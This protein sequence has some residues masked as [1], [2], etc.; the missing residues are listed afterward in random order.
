MC[1]FPISLHK[2]VHG[3]TTRYVFIYI[4]WLLTC[5]SMPYNLCVYLLLLPIPALVCLMGYWAESYYLE[6]ISQDVHLLWW[7]NS[8][9]IS[10]ESNPH[11]RLR[12]EK[13]LQAE[14]NKMRGQVVTCT[15]LGPGTCNW[16]KY[17]VYCIHLRQPTWTCWRERLHKCTSKI[18]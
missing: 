2:I 4:C 12:L 11:F 10:L 8:F 6:G 16:W 7:I 14:V 3:I 18:H 13:L 15:C 5:M 1:S 9:L 17:W